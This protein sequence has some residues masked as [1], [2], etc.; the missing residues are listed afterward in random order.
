MKF[1]EFDNWNKKI[2][3]VKH[4]NPYTTLSS[5]YGVFF[6]TKKCALYLKKTPVLKQNTISFKLIEAIL[7]S[8][9]G[10]SFI[11]WDSHYVCNGERQ[12]LFATRL[13]N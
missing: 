5:S 10:Q 4:L 13:H 9:D 2:S 1:L 7:Q 8:F 12:I 11:F 3:F 6:S